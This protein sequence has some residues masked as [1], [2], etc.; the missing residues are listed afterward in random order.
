MA[1]PFK[2]FVKGCPVN[3]GIKNKQKYFAISVINT[4]MFK[5]TH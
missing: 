3:L 2:P 1:I 5:I 4:L